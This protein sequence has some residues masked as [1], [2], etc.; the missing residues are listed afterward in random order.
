MPP[1]TLHDYSEGRLGGRT[2]PDDLRGLLQLQWHRPA[3]PNPL[4]PAREQTDPLAAMNVHILEA[5]EPNDLLEHSYLTARDMANQD[6]MAN[7]SAIR[8]V[9]QCASFVAVDRDRNVIGY[10]FGA[11][12]VPI[13]LAPIVRFDTEGQFM[14]MNGR[15]LA[16]ALV[17]DYA[18][19]DDEEFARLKAWLAHFSVHITPARWNELSEPS[20]PSHP[21]ALHMELYNK[22]RAQAG[23]PPI[24]A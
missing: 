2:I 19:D 17:G 15:T 11:E 20:S 10:W 14:L 3:L 9:C 8:E 1:R 18:F 24:K 23:L 7:V 21:R 16:E 22:N 12:N 5:G 6:L 4:A 13:E